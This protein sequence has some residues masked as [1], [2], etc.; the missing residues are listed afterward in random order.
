[1]NLIHE[2]T[3]DIAQG[4]DE[5]FET[6]TGA[7]S[8][9]IDLIGAGDQGM[10]FGYASNETKTLMPMPHYLASAWPSAWPLCARRYPALPA[11]RRQDPGHRALRGWQARRVTTGRRLHAAC[12]GRRG[13]GRAAM[14]EQ[15]SSR[16]SGAEGM[17]VGPT[18]T[19]TSTPPAASSS[20]APW[21]TPA[22][23]VARSSSTPTAAWAVTAAVPSRQGLHQGRP[24]RR[25]RRSLGRQERRR[26]GPGRPLRGRAG[27][28]HRRGPAAVA[29]GRDLRHRTSCRRKDRAR[30]VAEVFDLRPGAIIRDLDLRRPIYEKTA[31]YGH[32]GRERP[33]LH[34]G[35]TNRVDELKATCGL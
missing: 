24:L 32:F 28:R 29:H 16:P 12:R 33:G 20:A 19:S 5:S 23:P 9:P 2:Q 21:A 1:M 10:M 35:G 34:L 14:I 26:R 13:H 31:A 17:L 18:R 30:P 3:P 7:T 25:L 15:V 22:S 8:D 6:Q 4:V 27:L 11:P